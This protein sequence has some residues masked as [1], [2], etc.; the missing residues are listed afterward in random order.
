M[1]L[2][3]GVGHVNVGKTAPHMS[4]CNDLHQPNASSI[5]IHPNTFTI[6]C[7]FGRILLKLDLL[8]SYAKVPRYTRLTR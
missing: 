7:R 5:E 6:S 1:A 2:V 8:D 4:V 3:C